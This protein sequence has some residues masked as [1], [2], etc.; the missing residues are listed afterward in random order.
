[1]NTLPVQAYLDETPSLEKTPGM[2][3]AE[4]AA[5]S[6]LPAKTIRYYESIGLVAQPPRQ[7]NRYRCYGLA[8]L[9]VLR[10]MGRARQ[11]GLPLKSV[12]E[13]LSLWQQRAHATA[14][15]KELA[16][17]QLVRLDAQFAALEAR[18]EALRALLRRCDGEDA[19]TILDDFA[20]SSDRRG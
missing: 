3:I 19:A 1:M 20:Q 2:T 4:V 8:E 14:R 11:L 15:V 9:R 17:E 13:L 6:G 12:A 10:F 18:R 16:R 7:P 5:A